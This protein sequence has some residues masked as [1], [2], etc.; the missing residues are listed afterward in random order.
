MASTIQR[1]NLPPTS[2]TTTAAT[3]TAT[4]P[5]TLTGGVAI[6]TSPAVT[7]ALDTTV[8]GLSA[9]L[10]TAGTTNTIVQLLQNGV[11]VATLTIQA[12]QTY[13]FI[14]ISPSVLF[15]SRTDNYS[16][17]VAAAGTGAV[18]LGGEI[19]IQAH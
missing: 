7:P 3:K 16:I 4:I 14:A 12:N 10:E 17:S 2:S 8:T 11:A 15:H 5:Y 13:A 19:E 1:S 6:S 9:T 18:N